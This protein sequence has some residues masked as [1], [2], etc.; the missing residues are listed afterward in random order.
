MT[1]QPLSLSPTAPRHAFRAV[2]GVRLHWV[3]Y[4]A[5]G[6]H[7]PVVLLHGLNDSYLT[8]RQIAPVIAHGRHV[9]ALDLPGHGLSDRPDASYELTWYAQILARWIDALGVPAV[10]L[11]GH[12][13]GGGIA[14]A[15]LA[16]RRERVRRR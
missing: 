11:V 3:E 16:H 7:A 1:V 9:L 6:A 4:G 8:W 14:L 15:L 2:E 10:D 5:L 12:S 13:L